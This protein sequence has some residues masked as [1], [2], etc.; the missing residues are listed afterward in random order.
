LS[1]LI[2][3]LTKDGSYSLRSVF[4]QENFHSLFGALEETKSKFTATSN[5]QR[6]KG[7][8]LIVLDICFGLGY[9]SAS[10]LN[11]LIKQNSYLNLYALEIDKKPL[12]YSLRNE[13]FI[14]LWDP[15][16]KKIFK[17]LY[18]KDY[19]EDQFFK[20]SLLW[21]DAREK[22]NIIPSSIKFD[23]IYLDGFS[24]Q[25]C[26]QVWTIEFL[27]K[28]KEKLNS[29]GYLITYSSSAAV[30]KTLRNLG[31]EIFTIKP[32]FNNRTFWSQGTVAISKFDENKLKSNSNFEKLSLIEEEHLLTKASIPYRDKDLN[33]T[34]EDIIKNRLDE[35]LL[36]NLLSTKKWREKWG[37]TKLSVK[38]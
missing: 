2:E 15:K 3:V 23:L 19:F 20:C 38:S 9:N 12:E 16:V 30:R 36:S 33:S 6:L 27:S 13:S 31:L 14:K 5:L 22:I 34:K 26:P 17:S 21:G 32:R 18:R 1:E 35:Q 29:Q 11:E 24:P 10:L 28:V 25:K 7:K 4:F 37:M 8:S